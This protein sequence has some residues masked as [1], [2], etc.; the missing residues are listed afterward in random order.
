[1]Q[2][3]QIRLIGQEIERQADVQSSSYEG[4][5]PILQQIK[6]QQLSLQQQIE[7]S[8]QVAQE[9]VDNLDVLISDEQTKLERDLE[10]FDRYFQDSVATHLRKLE[11]LNTH[12][13]L[14][15]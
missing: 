9:Q 8:E 15:S 1:V 3:E 4:L 14:C 11:F 12:F 2:G 5:N 13:I 7:R 10:S 6:A